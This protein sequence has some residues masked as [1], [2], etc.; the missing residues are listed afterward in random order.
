VTSPLPTD[1]KT[2][3]AA[4]LAAVMAQGGQRV[5]LVDADLRRPMQHRLF[6]LSREPGLTSDIV[7][8][9]AGAADAGR[10]ASARLFSEGGERWGALQETDIDGLL[11]LTGGERA[12]NPA[13]L[14]SSHHFKLL[15]SW[16]EKQADVVIFDSPPVLAVTDASLLAN[17]VDGTLLVVD[18]GQTRRPAAVRAVERLNDVGANVLGV[19]LNRLAPSS[20]GYYYYYYYHGGYYGGEDGRSDRE[21][22]WLARLLGKERGEQRRQPRESHS[23]EGQRGGERDA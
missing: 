3:T 12:H 18:A 5:I 13:E 20:D 7:S 8:A 16:L 9:P 19:V 11:V 22:G 1:G 14:L 4:N 23:A 6:G 10:D 2:F 17:L 21:A 15:V